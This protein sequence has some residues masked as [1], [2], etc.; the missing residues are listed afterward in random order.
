M[1]IVAKYCNKS[2]LLI[3]DFR[4]NYVCTKSCA[5][6]F[7]NLCHATLRY[8]TITGNAVVY[9]GEKVFHSFYCIVHKT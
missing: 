9:N 4:G 1:R 8:K 2:F 3:F 5:V 6:N 7:F